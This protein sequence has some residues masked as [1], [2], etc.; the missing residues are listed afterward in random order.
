ME[1]VNRTRRGREERNFVILKGRTRL[2]EFEIRVLRRTFGPKE[3]EVTRKWRKLHDD[4]LHNLY[5][6]LNI[7]AV[8]K[9]KDCGGLS[10]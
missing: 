1:I 10:M 2:R 6:S 5:S 7:I 3:G 9:I 8:I 4:E